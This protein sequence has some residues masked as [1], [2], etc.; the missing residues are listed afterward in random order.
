MKIVMVAGEN[1]ISEIDDQ[2]TKAEKPEELIKSINAEF[3][4]YEEKHKEFFAKNDGI[5]QEAEAVLRD[6]SRPNRLPQRGVVGGHLNHNPPSSHRFL[7]K[8]TTYLKAK[9]F[10]TLFR[11]YIMDGFYP[12]PPHASG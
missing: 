4:T 12:H 6:Q 3:D 1:L 9:H 7:E 2:G 8:E 11:A 10:C 5:I